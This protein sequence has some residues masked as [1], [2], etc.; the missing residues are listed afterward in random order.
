VANCKPLSSIICPNEEAALPWR[1]R[2]ANGSAEAGNA[3]WRA[4]HVGFHNLVK[5]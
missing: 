1:M 4:Q 3:D 5:S 2:L